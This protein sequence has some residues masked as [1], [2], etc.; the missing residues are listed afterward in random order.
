MS[1]ILNWGIIGLGNIAY[2]FAKSFYNTN[3]AKLIAVASLSASKLD[4]FKKEFKIFDE[5]V[6]NEYE[7]LINN[8][9]IDIVYIALPNSF[10][11]DWIL[12][13]L[14][15]KKNILVE[16]PAIINFD[17]SKLIFEHPNFHKIFLS[18]GFMYRYHPQLIKVV[19]TIKDNKIGNLVSMKSDFGTNLIFK[20]NL[21]GFK[22]KKIDIKKRIFNKQL[23]GG[24]IYDQGC[25]PISMSLLIASL[26]DNLNYENHEIKNIKKDYDLDNLDIES[27]A[28]IIFDNQFKSFISTSF[29]N[30]FGN[31]T[32]I[33]GDQGEIEIKNSWNSSIGEISVIGK[34]P[35]RYITDISKSIYSLEIENVSQDILNNKLEASFPG[36]N[37]KEIYNNFILLNKWINEK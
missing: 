12:K 8:K 16:K 1:R 6:F 32:V 20:R 9:N 18:E 17:K 23:G 27:S 22:K 2:Q 7:K 36:M 14:D 26:I 37:K 21:F 30:N 11:D 13:A 34:D 4:I 28:E 5:Y 10:H 15:L 35:K 24:V 25:Y 31:K 29:K 33:Y 19:E 3:N